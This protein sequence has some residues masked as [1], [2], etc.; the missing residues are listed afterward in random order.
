MRSFRSKRKQHIYGIQQVLAS[1]LLVRGK[2][3]FYLSIPIIL[4]SEIE[5]DSLVVS[6]CCYDY[7]LLLL[8]IIYFV[9]FNFIFECDF[10]FFQYNACSLLTPMAYVVGR[11]IMIDTQMAVEGNKYGVKPNTQYHILTVEILD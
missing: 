10:S 3:S 6:C 1:S 5:Y 9:Y 11:I 7:Y 2:T 8:I 4:S